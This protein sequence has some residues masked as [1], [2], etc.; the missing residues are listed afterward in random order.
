MVR[1]K[2]CRSVA[3]GNMLTRRQSVKMDVKSSSFPRRYPS[4]RD[5]RVPIDSSEAVHMCYSCRKTFRL[6]N[7]HNRNASLVQWILYSRS[8][9][10]LYGETQRNI[11]AESFTFYIH[12]THTQNKNKQSTH[13]MCSQLVDSP[14]NGFVVLSSSSSCSS[15]IFL[16]HEMK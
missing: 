3:P 6:E 5:C 10:S 8:V 7:V 2:Q 9:G 14:F 15:S 16:S 4:S 12:S 11:V 13:T 1:S